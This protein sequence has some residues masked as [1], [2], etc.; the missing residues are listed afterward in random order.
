MPRLRAIIQFCNDG[1]ALETC[2]VLCKNSNDNT[3]RWTRRDGFIA[4]S[5]SAAAHFS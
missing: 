3:A 1:V 4:K 5:R 2:R